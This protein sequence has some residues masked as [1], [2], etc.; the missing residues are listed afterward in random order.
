[1]TTHDAE[2]L[3][4][5]LLTAHLRVENMRPRQA[6]AVEWS[7]GDKKAWRRANAQYAEMYRHVVRAMEAAP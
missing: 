4:N 1:M 7:D 6:A 3:L 2:T 5:D